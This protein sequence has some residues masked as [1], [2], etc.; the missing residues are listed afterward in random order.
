MQSCRTRQVRK[1]ESCCLPACSPVCLDWSQLIRYGFRCKDVANLYKSYINRIWQ[2]INFSIHLFFDTN[3]YK[4]LTRRNRLMTTPTV[5]RPP[6]AYSISYL[7]MS[8]VRGILNHY[9]WH[10]NIWLIRETTLFCSNVKLP[11]L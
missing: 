7:R 2:F 5:D 8:K 10:I 6:G 1:N 3:I 4:K 11:K 9:I